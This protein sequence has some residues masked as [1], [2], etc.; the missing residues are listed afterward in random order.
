VNPSLLAALPSLE[1]LFAYDAWA[2]AESVK[3]V[4]DAGAPPPA[5]RL[6]A[7]I[8]AAEELW[9][10]RLHADPAPVVVWP[11]SSVDEI[12]LRLDRLG[13]T[14]PAFVAGLAAVDLVQSVAYVNSKGEEWTT[15]VEDILLHVVIHSAYHRGQVAYVLRAGGATP[16]YTDYVHCIRNGL[17]E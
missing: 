10:G 7:H 3:A 13:R 15:S 5:V 2:N 11:E 4:R 1:R 6:M 12:E 9:K 17:I 16:A 14:W 8:A